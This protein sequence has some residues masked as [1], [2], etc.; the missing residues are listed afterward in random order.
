MT[1]QRGAWPLTCIFEDHATR[2]PNPASLPNDLGDPLVSAWG[3]FHSIYWLWR[4][5][6]RM[7]QNIT[8]LW[9]FRLFLVFL[10]WKK[11]MLQPISL[12]VN[13]YVLLW[14]HQW[15]VFPT[16]ERLSLSCCAWWFWQ[17]RLNPLKKSPKSA[18]PTAACRPFP[19]LLPTSL[20]SIPVF[21]PKYIKCFPTS[22]PQINLPIPQ[23]VVKLNWL[24]W[25]LPNLT[26][27][28][29]KI[30]FF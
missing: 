26:G 2:S 25:D 30:H 20:P 4:F 27:Q 17:I 7:Y 16:G 15:G 3:P 9:I 13:L 22:V 11:K 6:E 29:F 14:E 5:I 10:F 23:A 12:S 19:K 18:L 8:N 24:N 28:F 21:S 1:Q